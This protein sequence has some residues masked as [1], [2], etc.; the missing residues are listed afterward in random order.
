[1]A[2]LRIFLY[3]PPRFELDGSPST[4]KERKAI[5]LL[6]YLAVS[7]TRHSRDALAA[8]LWPKQSQSAARASLRHALWSLKAAGLGETIDIEQ[9]KIGIHPSYWLDVIE[10]NKR[11]N[12]HRQHGHNPGVV[13]SLCLTYLTDAIN[14]YTDDFLAGFT[15][16]DSPQFDDWQYYQREHWKQLLAYALE[17]L[18]R[19]HIRVTEWGRA[20]EYA[21]RWAALDPFHEPAQRWLMR[22]YANNNQRNQAL[23]Q[24]ETL[25]RTL[26]NELG[27]TPEKE[28]GDLAEAIHAGKSVSLK[29]PDRFLDRETF[30]DKLSQ[31]LLRA[32]AGRGR[33]VYLGAEA[34]GGKT[35]L[36]QHFCAEVQK[37]WRVSTGICDPL[38]TPQPLGPL[39]DIAAEMGGDLAH[40]LHT[41]EKPERIF[42]AFLQELRREQ[43]FHLVIFE[44]V[45][46]SD[47]ATLD[48]LRFIGRRIE[49]THALIIASFRDDEIE[50]RHPLRILLGDLAT[51]AGIERL[52]LPPLSRQA[53]GVLVTGT[54]F[55]PDIVYRKTGGNPFFVTEMLA[56]G[57][58]RIPENVRDAVLVRVACLTKPARSVLDSAAVFGPSVEASLLM[59][60]TGAEVD[61]IDECMSAGIILAHGDE[62]VF[63][64][65][66][67]WLAVLEAISPPRLLLLHRQALEALRESIRGSGNLARLAHHAESAADSKAVLE[68]APAAARQAAAAGAHRQA[69]AQFE[70]ALRFSSDLPDK[71][72]ALL[73][74]AYAR[75]CSLCDRNDTALQALEEARQIWKESGDRLKEGDNLS[76]QARCLYFIGRNAE[77]NKAIHS[78]IEI[79]SALPPSNELAYAYN[80]Y[81]RMLAYDSNYDAVISMAKKAI[82]M[83][84]RFGDTHT[85]I[86]AHN[87]IGISLIY[88]GEASGQTQLKRSINLAK[89][90]HDHAGVALGYCN[91]GRWTGL[92]FGWDNANQYIAEGLAYCAEFEM[93]FHKYFL[94]ASQASAHLYQGHWREAEETAKFVLSQDNLS[95]D[96]RFWALAV[97][98][99]VSTLRGNAECSSILNEA[100]ELAEQFG[101][102]MYLAPVRAIRAEAAWLAGEPNRIVEEVRAV[103]DLAVLKHHIWYTGELA[104]W[105]WRAGETVDLPDWAMPVFADQIRGDWAVAAAEWQ[106]RKCPY[107][108]ARALADGDVEARLIA[109]GIFDQLGAAPAAAMLRQTNYDPKIR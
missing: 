104:F 29:S 12:D 45:H 40:L 27:T 83:S 107:E 79:L 22:A 101:I 52:H 49:S 36:I 105:L 90:A 44:D 3:G 43:T 1:M 9:D 53:V 103:Y 63:R 23:R 16:R 59:R 2:G 100:L 96:T 94:F 11:L 85:L 4:I 54:E 8:M 95:A 76:R 62:L 86:M 106:R 67:A 30:I 72:R 65:E 14:L 6:V 25:K 17:C 74:Q 89:E 99:R 88:T 21:R 108:R 93:D 68:F 97:L 41:E 24:Y 109:L 69:T 56:S 73:L 81:A 84:E 46:W 80:Q 78:A 35:T 28:T 38:S 47:E 50:G 70:R 37:S 60:M 34:G 18:V 87:L 58:E 39:W 48:L 19:W 57:M 92:M 82:D 13:C 61:A 98:G 71:E 20:I 7:A 91:L 32:K 15:L 5:A 102:L 66:L 31:L 75:E 55:D 77:A 64:H 26:D 33:M 42:R 51:T 10:F